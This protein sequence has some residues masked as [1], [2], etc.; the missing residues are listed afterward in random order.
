MTSFDSLRS[1]LNRKPGAVEEFPFDTVTLV[2]K[3]G[4]KMF[5]LVGT[6]EIPLRLNL[7]CDPIKAEILREIYPTILPGYHMNKR[8]WNT[9]ILDGS[10]PA[11]EIRSMID[12]S[13]AL[14][15]RGLPRA[16]RP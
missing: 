12:D 15:V 5:A 11:T 2:V 7:K 6:D 8:H 10:I 13:Y 3:V 9:V 4:G 16:K 1:Y 14:V